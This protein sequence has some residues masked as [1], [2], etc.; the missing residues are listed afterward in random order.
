MRQRIEIEKDSERQ[1]ENMVETPKTSIAVYLGLIVETNLDL[2]DQN[3]QIIS[4]L[5]ERHTRREKTGPNCVLCMDKGFVVE[6]E[7]DDFGTPQYHLKPKR[8]PCSCQPANT[9]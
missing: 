6:Y 5:S 1:L 8:V 7:E 4:L 2:R 3:A 9:N